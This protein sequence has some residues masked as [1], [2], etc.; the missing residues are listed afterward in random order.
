MAR[1]RKFFQEQT[2]FQYLKCL[3]TEIVTLHLRSDSG[4]ELLLSSLTVLLQIVGHSVKKLE[5]QMDRPCLIN[6]IFKTPKD[7]MVIKMQNE[8]LL[9][10]SYYLVSFSKML[11]A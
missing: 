7:L 4:F 10:Y 5:W 3:R 11:L 9:M 1:A 2:H 8:T 6:T